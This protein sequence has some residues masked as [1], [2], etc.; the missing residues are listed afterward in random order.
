MRVFG[1]LPQEDLRQV[2]GAA[3]AIGAEGY[4]GV[5]APENQHDPFLALAVA[6]AATERIELHTGVAI[7]FARTPMA[8]ANVGWDLAGSTG[9]GF[10]IGLGSQV[11]AHNERRFSV[12]WSPPAPRMR[13]YVQVV[14]SIWR[15]WKTG[16]KP[17]YVG[18]HYKFTLMTRNST[19][20]RIAGPPPAVMIAAVGPA[21]LKV[22]AEECDGAKLHGFCTHKYLTDEIMPRVEAGLA[23]AGRKRAQYEISGGGF[24]ATGPDDEAVARRFEW[25]RQ[26]VAF[27]GSTPAYYPV[28]AVHGLEDLGHKLNEMTRQGRW[29]ERG[30]Q[31][32]G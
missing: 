25:V 20:P 11:R 22:A 12:P 6:G 13:E 2:A 21:M 31:G 5:V 10:V 19:P 27:Y 8:V 18:Q 7:A 1:T 26:R 4:D 23:K 9:G 29:G 15:C 32:R 14:R 28:L 17:T 30:A 24:L 16:E 3:R